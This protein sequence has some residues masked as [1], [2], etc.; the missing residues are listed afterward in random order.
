MSLAHL[1]SRIGYGTDIERFIYPPVPGSV[2]TPGAVHLYPLK[3]EI[4]VIVGQLG[5]MVRMSAPDLDIVVEGAN[6]GEAWALFL[7]ETKKRDD[8]AWL[9][10]DVG[11]TRRDEIEEGL[12]APEDEDWSERVGSTEG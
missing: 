6:R 9:S 2:D 8:G 5:H 7:D 12:N 4:R 3:Q 10:F 11:P 1:D